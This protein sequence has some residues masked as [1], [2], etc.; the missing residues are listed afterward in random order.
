MP[1][2]LEMASHGLRSQVAGTVGHRFVK[3]LLR[4]QYAAEVLLR[5]G[6]HVT[7]RLR[8]DQVVMPPP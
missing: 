8:Q 2:G 4:P 7:C 1:H 6:E 5:R 3:L